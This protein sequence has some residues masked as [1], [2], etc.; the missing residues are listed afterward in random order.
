MRTPVRTEESPQEVQ[1]SHLSTRWGPMVLATP[2]TPPDDLRLTLGA[3]EL[4]RRTALIGIIASIAS[5]P[6]GY[7]MIGPLRAAIGSVIMVL[8]FAGVLWRLRRGD[9]RTATTLLIATALVGIGFAHLAYGGLSGVAFA[10]LPILPTLAILVDTGS[11]ALGVQVGV[12]VLGLIGVSYVLPDAWWLVDQPS[13]DTIRYLRSGMALLSATSAGAVATYTVERL[14]AAMAVAT[15]T[16]QQARLAAE[17]KSSFL[18]NIS[19]ELRTP[20]NAILG[21]SELVAE[22]PA[23]SDEVRSD[24]GRI[25]RAGGELL[26]LIDEVLFLAR[27]DA[28]PRRAGERREVPSLVAGWVDASA[29]MLRLSALP[30]SLPR[31]QVDETRLDRLVA[32]LVNGYR[33]CGAVRVDVSVESRRRA[34]AV[35][36]RPEGWSQPPPTEMPLAWR[37]AERSAESA[38]V[39]VD[40]HDGGVAELVLPIRPSSPPGRPPSD[41]PVVEHEGLP[42]RPLDALRVQLSIQLVWLCIAIVCIVSPV[43]VILEPGSTLLPPLAVCSLLV[44]V[45]VM[46]RVGWHR[47]AS[48]TMAVGLLIGITVNQALAGGTA[49]VGMV[50]LPCVAILATL[51]VGS[52]GG[53]APTVLTGLCILAMTV[54]D[55]LGYLPPAPPDSRETVAVALT[56]ATSLFAALVATWSRPVEELVASASDAASRASA[57][58]RAT[59]S[60]LDAV[61]IELRTPLNAILGYAEL[62]LEDQEAGSEIHDDLTRIVEAGQHLRGV[63]DDLLDMSTIVADQLQLECEAVDIVELLP[64]VLV[65]VRPLLDRHGNTLEVDVERDVATVWADPKRLRQIL[66]NLLSNAAKFTHGGSVRLTAVRPHAHE[67]VIRVEDTGIGI[68]PEDVRELFQPFRQVHRGNPGKYGGTGLGLAISRRLARKMGGD[69]AVQSQLGRGSRFELSLRV[70]SR[71]G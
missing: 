12:L 53:Y 37:L 51:V 62:L 50:Y 57:A 70:A 15:E 42:D 60:F 1:G 23:A 3:T 43:L 21:Y 58:D 65:V 67:V 40:L 45:L 28:L 56:S 6:I 33:Q 22:D 47:T 55:E 54:A 18:A 59:S 5:F 35:G 7:A 61:S 4:I 10:M 39:Q 68:A 14:E 34:V 52:R 17:R 27:L 20:L 24:T 49:D 8:P 32:D 64:S 19:H 66:L 13:D 26:A 38:G 16:E 30:S 11:R 2:P 36:L 46:F 41:S 69:I 44:G 63:V 31:V 71:P 48:T 25:R 9:R 29:G